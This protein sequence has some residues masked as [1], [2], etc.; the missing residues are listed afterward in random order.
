MKKT[1]KVLSLL[2]I[3]LM[4]MTF[5]PSAGITALA[6]TDS[7]K[8]TVAS[9]T[10][11]P[12]STFNVD[13]SIK[14]NPGILGAVFTLSYDERL[15]LTNAVSGDAFSALA[16][17]KPGR[18]QSPCQF[19]WDGLELSESDIKDGVFLTLTFEASES[20]ENEATCDISLSYDDGDIVDA[21]LNPVS[22][23][24][25][26]GKVS[27]IDFVYGDADG[28][29]KV[30]TTDVILIR[31]F[32]AG[33]Y[34]T[35]INEKAANVN[36]DSKINMTDVIYIRRFIAGGYDIILPV[37]PA[38]TH[39]LTKEDEVP[40]KCTKGG[41]RAYWYC[42]S[43]GKYF[44]DAACLNETTLEAT[45]T[46]ALGHETVIDPAVPAT[47]TST[48]L[49]EGSHCSRC[50]EVLIPQIVIP[51]LEKNEYEITY[52]L[53]DGDTYLKNIGIDNPNPSVYS[54]EDGLTLEPLSVD[55]YIF[56]G[57]YDAESESA[58]KIVSIPVGTTGAIR[59]YAH[60]KPRE[61]TIQFNSPIAPV[62]SIT[63]TVDK[64]VTLSNP[65]WF[66]YTFV[67]W[68]DEDGALVSKIAK[69]SIG[70]L[71]LTA[72]WTSKRNQTV[73]V[74]QLDEPIIHEDTENGM[75]LFAYEI[76][77]I[78]NVP[79][80][81]IKD[82]ANSGGI[83][84]TETTSSTGSIS[85]T[86][87]ESIAN[88][89]SNATTKSDSWTLSESWNDST[90]ISEEHASEVGNE[91]INSSTSMHEATGKWSISGGTGGTHA[92]TTESGTSSKIG[93]ELGA[94]IGAGP[95]SVSGKMTGEEGR[96]DKDI[97]KNERNWNVNAGYEG[98][99][100]ASSSSST[101]SAFSSKISDKK[102]YSQT[103]AHNKA[104][105]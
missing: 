85:S 49:T 83:T 6:D 15:T 67:G 87:A 28:N 70:N 78:E 38:H 27:V 48:G 57:W 42:S 75:Y 105:S 26:N 91:V 32:I 94:N 77:R 76:G 44:S 45:V 59:L 89:V 58:Q 88:M 17:T 82:L 50:H 24:I 46:E 92:T 53:Y 81:K 101:S 80:Y 29:N 33:G 65:E 84:V 30:N 68:T 2:L 102:G 39:T 5:L 56:E 47:Y 14:D 95:Y 40:A 1:K 61:Y 103:K 12:G 3:L 11:T 21:D 93:A 41:H 72:N 79:L 7:P 99:S 73:P 90:T 64:G 8:I 19:T 98:S 35:K 13:I 25:T 20:I 97:E 37:Q 71:T 4:V 9:V 60:W 74:A 34:N 52:S 31:R 63:Y 54:K 10:T 36:L 66:G 96:T 51:I 86:S 62:D 23:T 104:N 18:Y 55:G 43:C 22:P 100:V 69:G 16:M